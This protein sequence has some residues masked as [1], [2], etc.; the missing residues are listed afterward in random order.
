[1]KINDILECFNKALDLQGNPDKIHYVAHSSWERKMGAIKQATTIITL[2]DPKVG[3]KEI[4]CAEYTAS[5]PAGQEDVLIEGA[6]RR[7]LTEFITK[8][9]HDTGVR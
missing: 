6:Q 9:N 4:I 7:A 5:I 3:A 8:W 1:M 2:I